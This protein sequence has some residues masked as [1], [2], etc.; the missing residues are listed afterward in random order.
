M[1]PLKLFSQIFLDKTDCVAGMIRR[2]G[3]KNTNFVARSVNNRMVEYCWFHII[4]CGEIKA[5][6]SKKKVITGKKIGP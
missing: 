3:R 1:P 2:N 5:T 6:N 4:F